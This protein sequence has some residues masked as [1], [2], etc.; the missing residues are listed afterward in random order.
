M[1][2]LP[3]DILIIIINLLSFDDISNLIQLFNHKIFEACKFY[4][5]INLGLKYRYHKNLSIFAHFTQ[6]EEL[7]VRNGSCNK[8]NI[9]LT[10]I[11]NN[12][13]LK[14]VILNNIRNI[15]PDYIYK[16]LLSQQNL[17]TLELY[18]CNVLEEKHLLAINKNIKNLSLRNNLFR[19]EEIKCLLRL[20]KLKKLDLSFSR[21]MFDV[22]INELKFEN[23]E[24]LHLSNTQLTLDDRFFSFLDNLK[25]LKELNLDF[26]ITSYQKFYKINKTCPKLE[27][28]SFVNSINIIFENDHRSLLS[29]KWLNIQ[30]L[31]LAYCLLEDINVID[32]IDNIPKV[33]NLN[34]NQTGVTDVAIIYITIMLK[35][36]EK[37]FINNNRITNISANHIAIYLTKLV[38]LD[39][40]HSSINDY[41]AKKILKNN[42]NIEKIFVTECPNITYRALRFG[43]KKIII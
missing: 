20:E 7:V 17:Q 40:S 32:I 14:K 41:Y 10:A 37:L 27:T 26:V 34:I 35:N 21:Y 38:E 31:N 12:W 36:I 29:T 30:D 43:V 23:L 9:C 1:I 15:H 25:K 24:I 3:L 22:N 2:D 4:K 16:F 28:F 5:K 18:L 11:K 42:I 33:K 19:F 6:L 39:I 8:N 13:R